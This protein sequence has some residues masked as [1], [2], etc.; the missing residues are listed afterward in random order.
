MGF[1]WETQIVKAKKA[2]ERRDKCKAKTNK[3]F[4]A[5]LRISSAKRIVE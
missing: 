2:K 4:L 1:D 5:K 3:S